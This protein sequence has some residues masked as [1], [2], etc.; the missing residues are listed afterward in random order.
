M[1]NQLPKGWTYN[2]L[3]TLADIDKDTL[4]GSTNPNYKFSYIDIGSV[5]TG[6]V[7][8]PNNEVSFSEAPSRARKK[9]QFDDVLMSTV[10]PNLKSFAHFKAKGSNFI[11]STGFAVLR[12][13][14]G[15]NNSFL[16]NAIL[17][18]DISRQIDA[19]VVGSNYPAINSSDVKNLEIVTPSKPEQQKIAAILTSV[20][21]VIEKTQAQI[22][23]L[24]DL[25]TGMMQ[26]LLTRGIGIDGKPHTEFKDS[27]VGRIPKGWDVWTLDDMSEKRKPVLKTGPF[28]SSLKSSDFKEKG[29]PVINIQNLGVGK[30]ETKNI[31]FVTNEKARELSGYSVSEGDLVFSRVAD[32]GRSVVI[33]KEAIGWIMSSNLMR[34]STDKSKVDSKYLMYQLVNGPSVTLQLNQMVSDGGRQVVTGPTIKQLQFPI[35][36]I[37]EQKMIVNKIDSIDYYLNEKVKKVSQLNAIKKALMQDLLTGKVRV[38]VD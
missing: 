1:S 22:N 2:L 13:K 21:D 5:S 19:L 36:S 33:P 3:S 17:S 26:E 4:K 31:Y 20:D 29:V 15:N 8:L 28:G 35:P 12:A 30:L 11:A 37:T 18:D 9:V 7:V 14:N 32:V 38:N 25:K 10:R 23:K 24:K 34:I 27:P 6:K 16:F